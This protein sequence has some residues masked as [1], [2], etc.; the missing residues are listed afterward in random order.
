MQ[1]ITTTE[2]RTKSK[3]LVKVLGEGKSVDLIHR[4]RVVGE[5]TPKQQPK[6]FNAKRFL[7]IVDKLNLPHLNDKEIDRRY[8][9]AMEAKHGKNL[10]GH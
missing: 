10:P 9:K 5:I 7:K 3:R 4:S 2:L 1:I 8:R 6:I